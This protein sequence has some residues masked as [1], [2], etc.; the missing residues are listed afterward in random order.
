MKNL[1]IC[2]AAVIIIRLL[3]ALL[4][5]EKYTNLNDTLRYGTG[6]VEFLPYNEKGYTLLCRLGGS[7]D[8]E[9]IFCEGREATANRN[10]T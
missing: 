10:A 6:K 4:L 1:F 8:A 7:K 5:F 2:L 3:T 9:L